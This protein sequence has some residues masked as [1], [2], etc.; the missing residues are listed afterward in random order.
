VIQTGVLRIVPPVL[1]AQRKLLAAR[2]FT[3]SH[4]AGAGKEEN[5]APYPGRPK[6][7]H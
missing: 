2:A 1:V 6:S 3:V 5:S 4:R 7:L